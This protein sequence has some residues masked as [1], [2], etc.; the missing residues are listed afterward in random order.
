MRHLFEIANQRGDCN[1]ARCWNAEFFKGK[2]IVFIS[3]PPWPEDHGPGEIVMKRIHKVAIVLVLL[4]L[5]AV[6]IACAPSWTY[7]ID[8]V[9]FNLSNPSPETSG[10]APD[11]WIDTH[12]DISGM[13]GGTISTTAPYDVTFGYT[14]EEDEEGVFDSIDMT[15]ITITYDDEIVEKAT[16]KLELPMRVDAREYESYNSMAG[17]EI[18]KSISKGISGVIPGVIT[19]DKPFTLK[20]KGHFNKE[21]GT[22]VPFEI[23]Q[24]YDVERETGTASWSE[25]MSGC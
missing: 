25:V 20:L 22:K 17:G 6:A 4:P 12:N 7:K 16:D 10:P 2:I 1:N 15:S 23:D 5:L 14:D 13:F 21:D 3:I 8:S 9:Q 11:I 24:H 19:R 18:V